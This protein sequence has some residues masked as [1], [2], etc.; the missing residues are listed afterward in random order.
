[1]NS[2]P[3][4]RGSPYGRGTGKHARGTE[5]DLV[6]PL[7]FAC[8]TQEKKHSSK[9]GAGFS[10]ANNDSGYLDGSIADVETD[11]EPHDVSAGAAEMNASCS[12]DEGFVNGVAQNI[13]IGAVMR[14]DDSE[15]VGN[16]A[17]S[18]MSQQNAPLVNIRCPRPGN[19][20]T[21]SITQEEFGRL[22]ADV[23]AF[24]Y[25]TLY[26]ADWRQLS[27]RRE[28]AARDAANSALDLAYVRD[29]HGKRPGFSA[30]FGTDWDREAVYQV[31]K[32]MKRH[33][34]RAD[35]LERVLNWVLSDDVRSYAPDE[36]I[37]YEQVFLNLPE[38][39][40]HFP[41]PNPAMSIA[42]LEG[43]ETSISRCASERGT[44]GHNS[45]VPIDPH[46]QK[47]LDI[48][49]ELHRRQANVKDQ[50]VLGSITAETLEQQ[51]L[52]N[53]SEDNSSELVHALDHYLALR[54][55]CRTLYAVEHMNNTGLANGHRGGAA[56]AAAAAAVA[57]ARP[58]LLYAQQQQQRL[59]AMANADGHPLLQHATNAHHAVHQTAHVPH[60]HH[61]QQQ[62][63][64][65]QPQ[66][67]QQ[68]QQQLPYM[69][70][71]PG[72]HQRIQH[73]HQ[74]LQHPQQYQ[75]QQHQHSSPRRY[76]VHVTNPAPFESLDAAARNGNIVDGMY[77]PSLPRP[78]NV[79][80]GRR[81]QV[82]S[83]ATNTGAADGCN[84]HT[85]AL[86][87]LKSNRRQ[88]RVHH[89][90]AP[91]ARQL[92]NRSNSFYTLPYQCLWQ[93]CGSRFK[94]SQELYTHVERQHIKTDPG[95]LTGER[96]FSCQWQGCTSQETS[97]MAQLTS[98]STS[99]LARDFG[100]GKPSLNAKGRGGNATTGRSPGQPRRVA[101]SC[102]ARYQLLIHIQNV[103]CKEKMK[104]DEQIVSAG[105]SSG[106]R[107]AH[108]YASMSG[109]ATD[110]LSD[111]TER[112]SESPTRPGKHG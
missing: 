14:S 86:G 75:Q 4:P 36:V 3:A 103:H 8:S 107:E 11:E 21:V 6:R 56:A 24:C 13:N 88:K 20:T 105:L 17:S 59:Q 12:F 29:E 15:V 32:D 39:G 51:M 5:A 7:E 81:P 10:A 83:S 48:Y 52:N 37:E 22:P 71:M 72:P 104:F 26:D 46:G 84:R 35:P 87:P 109:Q 102:K 53:D 23:A 54:R 58:H 28:Q 50:I 89:P 73:Q 64:Q 99:N 108:A 40:K 57:A 18:F 112:R 79:L 95:F 69:A 82:P 111:I 78:N 45:P 1:M 94:S 90:P 41:N 91:P 9:D 80:E 31:W 55:A 92:S 85:A 77:L 63:Y 76:P 61:Q 96:G 2:Q 97:V 16:E 49:K 62:H 42:V 106:S 33:L 67:H 100:P 38:R 66:Q 19:D 98:P 47:I 110:G 44:H 60:H 27:R 30:M 93:R 74:Q 101:F 70:P 34:P 68:Q 65:Q 25:I 43:Y